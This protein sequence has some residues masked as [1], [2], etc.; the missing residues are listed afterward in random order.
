MNKDDARSRNMAAIKS[1]NT[2]PEIYVRKLLFSHGYRYR[3]NVKRI[4]GK[5]DLYLAKYKTAVFVNGCFWHMHNGC[6]YFVWP[7]TNNEFWKEKIERN[8]WIQK[9]KDNPLLKE[10]LD[11]INM[12]NID[13]E[14]LFK[15]KG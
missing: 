14:I 12:D 10:I 11:S 7:K 3:I 9:I 15:I 13:K 2:K 5:P 4:S 8:N 6:K 1:K